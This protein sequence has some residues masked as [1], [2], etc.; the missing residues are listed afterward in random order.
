MAS[1]D[2]LVHVGIPWPAAA[3]LGQDQ[4]TAVS[5]A[6]TTQATATAL[7]AAYN[8]VSTCANGAGV[9][10]PG[11]SGQPINVIQN[12]GANTLSIYVATGNYMNGTL[13]GSLQ[14]ASGNGAILIPSGIRWIG[15]VAN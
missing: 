10:L 3:A 7:T 6:G 1:K 12:N 15:I 11:A 9:V 14:V 13:N 8:E 5:A 2:E 4:A